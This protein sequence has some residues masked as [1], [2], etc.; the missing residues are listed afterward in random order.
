MTSTIERV[1][2][3]FGGHPRLHCNAATVVTPDAV[4]ELFDLAVYL[5]K[6]FELAT[7]F[8]EVVRGDPRD[9]ATRRLGRARLE[10]LHRQVLPIYEAM[11]ARLF[12]QLPRGGRVPLLPIGAQGGHID[13]HQQR[14]DEEGE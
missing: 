13:Q 9:P 5:F 1:E 6:R 10:E 3:R 7:H 4:D 8:F 11:A 2:R 14:L 12:D